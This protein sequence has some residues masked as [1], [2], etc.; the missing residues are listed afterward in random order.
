M[1]LKNTA[2]GLA[3]SLSLVTPVFAQSQSTDAAQMTPATTPAPAVAPAS[4]SKGVLVMDKSAQEQVIEKLHPTS[5]T[6]AMWSISFP[7]GIKIRD[8]AIEA[9]KP[10]FGPG[11]IVSETPQAGSYALSLHNDDFSY[12]WDSMSSLGLAVTPRVTFTLTVE[13]FDPNGKSLMK[14]AYV[15]KDFTNGSY[16]ASFKP[17]EKVYGA[18]EAGLKDV[19][20]EMTTDINTAMGVTPAAPATPPVAAEPTPKP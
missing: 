13:L 18:F 4:A 19:F 15:R 9:L 12:K 11:L 14:K 17:K 3:L 8:T 5:F 16:I 6:G 7:I 10:T 2:L 1:S 20:A